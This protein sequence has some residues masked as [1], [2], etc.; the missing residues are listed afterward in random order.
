MKKKSA[1]VTKKEGTKKKDNVVPISKYANQHPTPNKELV[2]INK[3][4]T[5]NGSRFR[6]NVFGSQKTELAWLRSQRDSVKKQGSLLLT[7]ISA[8]KKMGG[9]SVNEKSARTNKKGK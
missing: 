1:T 3:F 2:V 9:G 8:V 4:L 5:D 6:V 7:A